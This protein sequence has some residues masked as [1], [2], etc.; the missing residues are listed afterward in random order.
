MS[1]NTLNRGY[2]GLNIIYRIPALFMP[3]RSGELMRMLFLTSYPPCG[4]S[5][6]QQRGAGEQEKR[7]LL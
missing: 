5:S 1:G 6:G 2:V 3:Y 4:V 7:C